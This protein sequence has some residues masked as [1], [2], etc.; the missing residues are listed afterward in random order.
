VHGEAQFFKVVGA[1]HSLSLVLGPG[2]GGQEH[3]GQ[4]RDNGNDHQKLNEGESR[5]PVSIPI[6]GWLSQSIHKYPAFDGLPYTRALHARIY[7]NADN[8]N[9]L[10]I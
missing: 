8:N 9:L 10:T 5:G 2:Q 4:N 7:G 6:R 3:R 1:S